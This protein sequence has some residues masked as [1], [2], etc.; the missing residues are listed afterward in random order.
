MKSWTHA[1]TIAT[2]TL[3]L[4]AGS[5]AHASLIAY[6]GFATPGDYTNGTGLDSQTAGGTGNWSGDYTLMTAGNA[7]ML[8]SSTASMTYST[9]PTTDGSGTKNTSGT[10]NRLEL[11]RSIDI[12]GVF[13]AN[14]DV[15][16]VGLQGQL[17]MSVLVNRTFGTNGWSVSLS[18]N[19]TTAI[20]QMGVGI[21]APNG[22]AEPIR[23]GIQGTFSTHADTAIVTNTTYFVVARISDIVTEIVAGSPPTALR[24]PV[25]DVWI[26]PVIDPDHIDYIDLASIAI[27]SGQQSVTRQHQGI[28]TTQY[29]QIYSHQNTRIDFDEIRIGTT[30]DSV[31]GIPEPGSLVLMALSG[32]LMFRR[33]HPR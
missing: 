21:G 14:E 6:E 1:L 33:T 29:L 9:L 23:A 10:N 25:V 8:K 11:A 5:Q 16:T 18:H 32:L 31:I 7:N 2:A 28:G 13:P 15:T 17:W 19:N 20:S 27:G 30:F 26:N 3:L 4:G 12:G 24:W 22:S